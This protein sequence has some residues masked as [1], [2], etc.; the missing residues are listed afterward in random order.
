MVHIITNKH[1]Q[2]KIIFFLIGFAHLW[3]LGNHMSAVDFTFKI[4]TEPV[5]VKSFLD[6]QYDLQAQAVKD[7]SM[8]LIRLF[9]N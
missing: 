1:K 8:Q 7:M 6:T 2:T 4:Q 5:D 3:L 9:Q